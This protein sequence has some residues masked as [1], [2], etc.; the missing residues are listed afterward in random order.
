MNRFVAIFLLTV[1]AWVRA[2]VITGV[3]NAEGNSEMQAGA[4]AGRYDSRKFKFVDR[5]NYSE[6]RDFVVC[7]EGPVAGVTNRPPEI[8]SVVTTN[9]T[10]RDAAFKPHVLPVFAGTTVEWPNEDDIFHNVFSMSEAKPFDLGLYKGRPKEKA[11]VFD[12]TGR[13]DVFCSIHSQMHCV[14]LVL[15]NPFFAVTDTRGR[16][17]IRDVPAGTYKLKAWHER[18]PALTQ[19]VTVSETGEVKLDFTLGI[20]NLPKY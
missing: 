3:V 7:I 9:L 17:A 8:R 4:G 5:I 16:Y 2:G 15:E 13:V 19:D 14:V 10:Q 18:L 11:I 1:S 6:L 12:K 20:K